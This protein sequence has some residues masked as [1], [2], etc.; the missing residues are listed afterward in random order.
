[1]ISTDSARELRDHFAILTKLV[2]KGHN[3]L[4]ASE[5]GG[6][7]GTTF[8]PQFALRVTFGSYHILYGWLSSGFSVSSL[9][10]TCCA[11]I[12]ASEA[13]AIPL[14]CPHLLGRNQ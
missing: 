5:I 13:R 9:Q 1:M 12:V 7:A 6:S 3:V 4:L 8:D 11:G 2:L 14:W 10:H